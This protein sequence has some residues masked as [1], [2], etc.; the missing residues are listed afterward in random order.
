MRTAGYALARRFILA[1]FFL[2]LS[3]LLIQDAWALPIFSRQIGRDC[4]YCHTLIPKLNETGRVFRSNGFRFEAEGE[5]KN[6]KDWT[7]VPVSVEVALE[8]FDNRARASGV[9]TESSDITIDE[10]ELFAGGVIGKSGKVSARAT[11]A[12][13]PEDTDASTFKAVIAQAYIQVNDLAGGQGEGLLNVKAGHDAIGLP[14]LSARQ[15]VIHRAYLADTVLGLITKRQRF[16]ELNGIVVADE[17][18]WSPTH[19][20]SAGI[21]REDVNSDDKIKGH[22]ATYAATFKEALSIGFIYR[23]GEERSGAD[24]TAYRKYGA[25]LEAA[26][27]SVILDIG[28]FRSDRK[29]A[30]D[31]GDFLAEVFFIP[32]SRWSLGARFETARQKGKQGVKEHSFMARYGVLSNVYAQLEYT[33]LT[34]KSHIAGS[35]ERQR[36]STVSLVALF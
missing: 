16:V 29:E 25:A 33:G 2:I 26:L 20:Y 10:V 30:A 24:D 15:R 21:S 28:Y 23:R 35:N 12:I 17:E 6:V 34:D 18:S 1:P 4:T 32:K 31:I 3:F 13:E 8:A 5:W 14:F 22:F 11:L 9:D 27:G 36:E 19:R 7:T